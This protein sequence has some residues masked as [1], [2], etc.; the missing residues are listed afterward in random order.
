MFLVCFSPAT[1]GILFWVIKRVRF[2]EKYYYALTSCM[3]A[4][5]LGRARAQRYIVY[6]KFEHGQVRPCLQKLLHISDF[7]N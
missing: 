3:R 1:C 2:T 7:L 4:W 6:L 5:P